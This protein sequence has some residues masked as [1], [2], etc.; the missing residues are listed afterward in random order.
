M[1]NV[2]QF[3]QPPV[4]VQVRLCPH[5]KRQLLQSLNDGWMADESPKAAV[6]FVEYLESI[7]DELSTDRIH[8]QDGHWGSDQDHVR[9]F[10]ADCA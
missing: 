8:D 2:L 5:R 4:T 7:V 1:N 6:T 3:K 10:L 9:S